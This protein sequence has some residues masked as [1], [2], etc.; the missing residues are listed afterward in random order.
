[1][2]EPLSIEM[3]RLSINMAATE[4]RL[5]LENIASGNK[6]GANYQAVDFSQLIESVQHE[7]D[8]SRIATLSDNWVNVEATLTSKTT[9]Q[10]V[11]DEEV[12][13]SMK[14]AGKYQ[15]MIE[16]LNRKLALAELA[17]NGGKR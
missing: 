5:T 8:S 12:A 2:A 15:K 3:L 9:K 17:T 6:V 7:S 11:L 14:A 10:V 4:Q 1:M 16:V 13:L